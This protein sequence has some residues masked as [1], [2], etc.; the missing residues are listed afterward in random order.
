MALSV[1]LLVSFGCGAKNNGAKVVDG[2][3]VADED[4]Y[5]H[6][7]C[8]EFWELMNGDIFRQ[9]FLKMSNY[10]FGSEYN[11]RMFAISGTLKHNIAFDT[12]QLYDG[13]KGAIGGSSF[14]YDPVL[15]KLGVSRDMDYNGK[16]VVIRLTLKEGD[17]VTE[18]LRAYPSAVDYSI[19]T[20]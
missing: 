5:I 20:K 17:M 1:L 4:G 2:R 10:E 12:M 14:D 15:K 19:E 16:N 11:G 18:T 8:Y 9:N 7:T 6:M 3:L 13:D